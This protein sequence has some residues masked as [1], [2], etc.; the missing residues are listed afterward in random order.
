M[1]YIKKITI[2][3][4]LL[5]AASIKSYG[6]TS[7]DS[8]SNGLKQYMFV[9]YTKGNNRN[10][11]STTAQRIQTQH[12]NHLDSLHALGLLNVAGPFMEDGD[13]RGLLVLDVPTKEEAEALV[14]KD[15][16]VIAGRLNY[17]ILPWMTQKGNCFR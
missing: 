14:K 10:H 8:I 13:W 16:A 4:L 1:N 3:A 11:D 5:S 2:V 7:A 9:M 6:Q 17:V 15:P 12:L